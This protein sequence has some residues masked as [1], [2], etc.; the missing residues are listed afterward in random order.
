MPDTQESRERRSPIKHPS[1]LHP[2]GNFER[3]INT[4]YQLA[5]CATHKKPLRRFHLSF[6]RSSLVSCAPGTVIQVESTK[7]NLVGIRNTTGQFD[8]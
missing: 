4:S 2:E 5:E 1:N 8:A 3:P 6:E 7:G